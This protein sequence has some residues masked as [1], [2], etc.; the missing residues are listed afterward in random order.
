[1]RRISTDIYGYEKDI[2]LLNMLVMLLHQDP[3]ARLHRG[4]G[5]E[6]RVDV[7]ESLAQVLHPHSLEYP[8][9]FFSH[10]CCYG[11]E[12]ISMYLYM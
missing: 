6:T 5:P 2:H 12:V 8:S 10:K 1:M 11:C 7:D 3:L 4:Q 9:L